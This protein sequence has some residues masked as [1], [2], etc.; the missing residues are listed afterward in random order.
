MKMMSDK[1]KQDLRYHTKDVAD[2]MFELRAFSH[3]M[4]LL[5]E[6]AN[7]DQIKTRRLDMDLVFAAQRR[8][9]TG[10]T[11]AFDNLTTRLEE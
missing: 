8:L 9:F 4:E 5:F 10:M 1:Q 11:E 3:A 6:D 2:R 7:Y